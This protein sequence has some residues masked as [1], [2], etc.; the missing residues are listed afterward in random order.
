MNDIINMRAEI[1]GVLDGIDET[2]SDNF[3][4]CASYW[5]WLISFTRRV[6]DMPLAALP[7][8]PLAGQVVICRG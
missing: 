4:V 7:S 2:V 3:Q 6:S 5:A 8:H 1:I